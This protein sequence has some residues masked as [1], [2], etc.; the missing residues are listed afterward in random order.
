LSTAPSSQG[1]VQLL[2]GS[3]G[4]SESKDSVNLKAIIT[5]YDGPSPDQ[6]VGNLVSTAL[7][8]AKDADEI[9]EKDKTLHG[10][11]NRMK[12]GARMTAQFMT[13]YRGFECPVKRPTL[14]SARNFA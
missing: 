7:Q 5:F 13:G 3:W 1:S 8:R 12:N 14:F 4:C 10:T 2:F 9:D 6:I 11:M